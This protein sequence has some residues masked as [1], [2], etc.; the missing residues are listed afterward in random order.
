MP[1]VVRC[2]NGCKLRV[3]VRKLF[4]TIQC[5]KC[6]VALLVTKEQIEKFQA[7]QTH[8]LT[9]S[10]S[11]DLVELV[12][13]SIV[14]PEG[15]SN[16]LLGKVT[17]ESVTSPKPP[18]QGSANHPPPIPVETHQQTFSPQPVP[19]HLLPFKSLSSQAG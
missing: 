19:P 2:P 4:D 15:E 13:D 6:A 5:P 18:G 14:S 17:R 12:S 16:N 1:A 11:S 10:H 8:V 9:A 3:P 7:D